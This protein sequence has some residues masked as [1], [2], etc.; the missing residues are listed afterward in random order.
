MQVT[1]S[2]VNWQKL[3]GLDYSVGCEDAYW[4]NATEVEIGGDPHWPS[5]SSIQFQEI[6]MI[7]EEICD[8]ISEPTR[9]NAGEVIE[10][11]FGFTEALLWD[12]QSTERGR[13][14]WI[15][16][17][18]PASVQSLLEKFDVID[19]GV[20]DRAFDARRESLQDEFAIVEHPGEEVFSG[21]F[22][23][24]EALL[25]HAATN[26]AGVIIWVG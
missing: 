5:D 19:Y 3:E 9:G 1:A 13:E 2:A 18:S 26:D 14:C 25:R 21:Y 12:L 11:L 16:A 23:Q 24:W 22:R 4:A 20:L 10:R 8:D 17:V 6:G 7:F 15:G